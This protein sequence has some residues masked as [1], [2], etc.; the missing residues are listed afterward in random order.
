MTPPD[1]TTLIDD[2]LD[3][4]E[5][6]YTLT[7]EVEDRAMDHGAIGLIAPLGLTTDRQEWLGVTTPEGWHADI[8]VDARTGQSAMVLTGPAWISP[9]LTYRFRLRDKGNLPGRVWSRGDTRFT[10]PSE[11]LEASVAALISEEPSQ[12]DALRAIVDSTTELFDYAHPD[13]HFFDDEVAIPALSCGID[14]SCIDINTYLVSSC[15][16]AGIDAAYFAGYFFPAERSGITNDMHCW[17][18]T[19]ADGLKEE[20]DIAHHLK[21]DRKQIE[22]GYNP[23]PGMRFAL[24]FD[25]GLVFDTLVGPVEMGHFSEPEWLLPRPSPDAPHA[26]TAKAKLTVTLE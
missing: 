4:E 23:R 3:L 6:I 7:V 25:R 2:I 26:S 15:L 19:R 24:S 1:T 13:Q 20:W 17:V 8:V 12:A 21:M 11:E 10:R 9:T 22:P 18:A 14:G 16:A 5:Q